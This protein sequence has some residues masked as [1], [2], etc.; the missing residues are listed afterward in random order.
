MTS[1][2]PLWIQPA[3][4]KTKKC[5]MRVFTRPGYR[6]CPAANTG[7]VD[8]ARTP[9]VQP[10]PGASGFGTARGNGPRSKSVLADPRDVNANRQW[11]RYWAKDRGALVVDIGHDPGR[12]GDTGPFYGVERRSLYNNWT[13][14]D[15]TVVQHDPGF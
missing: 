1:C 2:C 7:R 9:R 14:G 13:D 10:D 12:P 4:V 5:S 15:V 11:L 3:T 6:R 8:P